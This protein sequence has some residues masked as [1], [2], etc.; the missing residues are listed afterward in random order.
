MELKNIKLVGVDLD[1]TLFNSEKIIDAG[2]RS[3][4]SK[5][6]K[7]GIEI[8]PVTGRPLGG[9]SKE[10]FNTPEFDFA[11]TNNG[12]EITNLK[13]GKAVFSKQTECQTS[14]K[15]I[16]AVEKAG[17]YY[18]VFANG[19]GRLT[20]K[21]FDFYINENKNEHIKKY[22]RESRKIVDDVYAYIESNNLKT[23]EIL[24]SFRNEEEEK[25]VLNIL[26]NVKN[27]QYWYLAGKFIEI[28][29]Y[30]ADKG[31]AFEFLTSYM[32]LK[33]EN[34]LA[35]GDGENDISLLKSAGVSVAV[36]NAQKEILE[37]ADI[38]TL[39]NDQGGIGKII[40]KL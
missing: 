22:I 2:T 17:L 14:L 32:G 24:V 5:A 10:I 3:A 38:V 9:L 15:I 11:I 7:R 40:E 20:K 36:S 35:A 39:S 4:I 33:K 12:A 16:K 19:Y 30:G 18:E 27:I 26:S 25:T 6:K 8:V 21:C 28:T 37:M 31:K 13:T 1:G 29:N 23:D 34:T